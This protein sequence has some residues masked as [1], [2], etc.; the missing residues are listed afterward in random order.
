MAKLLYCIAGLVIAI[1]ISAP[2]PAAA[3]GREA[4][5]LDAKVTELFNAGKYQEAIPL[6]ERSLAIHEQMFGRDNLKVANSVYNLAMLHD[7]QGRR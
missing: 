3:Q 6:A 7:N 5:A 4:A 1:A 2:A